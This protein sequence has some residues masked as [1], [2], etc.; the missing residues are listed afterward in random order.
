WKLGYKNGALKAGKKTRVSLDSFGQ[1]GGHFTRDIAFAPDGTLYLAIGSR[2]NMGENP[3]P[4][5]SVQIVGADGHL[6]TFAD[7]LRNP[8]G[9]AFYPGTNDLW[10]TVN[11]RDGL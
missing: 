5:A 7:G 8:V 9:I 11:E 4:R 10:V 3:L 2:D 6:T 1:K